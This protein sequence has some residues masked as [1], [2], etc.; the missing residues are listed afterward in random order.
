M[1]SCVVSF[2]IKK[3]FVDDGLVGYD[4]T[5]MRC[6]ACYSLVNCKNA[7]LMSGYSYTV[8]NN[9]VLL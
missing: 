5:I 4:N 9:V 1:R 3:I 6:L 8:L 7:K 2:I